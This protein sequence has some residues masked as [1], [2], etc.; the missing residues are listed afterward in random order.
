MVKDTRE[1][2]HEEAPQPGISQAMRQHCRPA[3]PVGNAAV[4]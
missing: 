1:N 3:I 2:Q 4:I